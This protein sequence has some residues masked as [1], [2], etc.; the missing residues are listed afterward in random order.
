MVHYRK[1]YASKQFE[2]LPFVVHIINWGVLGAFLGVHSIGSVIKIPVLF[3]TAIICYFLA[4]GA[5]KRG[6]KWVYITDT[7]LAQLIS[8]I[9]IFSFSKL[10]FSYHAIL[11]LA[12]IESIFFI[13]V[14]VIEQEKFLK[15]ISS[16]L[17]HLIGISIIIYSTKCALTYKTHELYPMAMILLGGFFYLLVFFLL[18]HKKY[19]E[20]FDCINQYLLAFKNKKIFSGNGFLLC[21]FISVLLTISCLKGNN[22]IFGWQYYALG[23]FAL[24]TWLRY[25]TESFGISIGI[26][27]LLLIAHAF[28]WFIPYM[29]NENVHISIK[30]LNGSLLYIATLLFM[31]GSKFNVSNKNYYILGIWVCGAHTLVFSYQILHLISPLIPGIFWL[32]LTP[33]I[34]E[35]SAMLLRYKTNCSNSIIKHIIFQGHIYWLA[36]IGNHIFSQ[37]QNYDYLGPLQL[38]VIFEFLAIALAIYWWSFGTKYERFKEL[39]AYSKLQPFFLELAISFGVLATLNSIE[40]LYLPIMWLVFASLF[41]GL[42]KLSEHLKRLI[43]YSLL[44][45]YA[46]FVHL[47][48]NTSSM[49][50]PYLEFYRQPWFVGLVTLVCSFPLLYYYSKNAILESI[51]TPTAL[52]LV[53]KWS[54]SLSKHKNNWLFQPFFITTALFMFWRFDHTILTFLWVMEIFGIFTLGIIL[55]ENI[56]RIISLAALGTVLCR[57]VFYDMVQAGTLA[58]GLVFLGVGA[59]MLIMNT[60]W[61][62]F[63][64]RVAQK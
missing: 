10:N 15:V 27:A 5:K 58:R 45:I 33:L 16:I 29:W 11:M 21:G 61:T 37:S 28:A 26:T 9:A 31:V 19:G 3:A 1:D 60:M 56:F 48:A 6:I 20:E 14:T 55:K 24:L 57:L 38:K 30:I 51:E 64:N 23:I 22:F 47:V 40:K 17:S 18:T 62:H 35:I 32:I 8:L 54:Q 39:T 4:K 46:A 44:F 36:F 2:L 41:L 43:F 34:L 42:G 49:N 25:Q 50:V 59:I 7:L 63:K 13:L 52:A 12:F 53:K